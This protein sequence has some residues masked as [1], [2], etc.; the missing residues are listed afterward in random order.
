MVIS[1]IG[2]DLVQEVIAVDDPTIHYKTWYAWANS[3]FGD[4]IIKVSEDSM[5]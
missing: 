4:F 1:N 5:M 2:E 3:F